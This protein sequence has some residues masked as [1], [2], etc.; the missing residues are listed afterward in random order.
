MKLKIL[1]RFK[2]KITNIINTSSLFDEVSD[3]SDDI[4]TLSIESLVDILKKNK[5]FL[6]S[7]DVS[8]FI[9]FVAFDAGILFVNLQSGY[10][11]DIIKNLN[12]FFEEKKF[13]IKVEH[14]SEIGEDTLEQKKQTLFNQQLEEAKENPILKEIL[15]CFSNSVVANIENL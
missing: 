2:K 13:S 4:A 10:P 8:K 3:K 9:R 12:S 14:S 6:L 11:K 5:S 7:Q 15:D 1:L